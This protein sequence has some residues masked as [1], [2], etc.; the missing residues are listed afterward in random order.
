MTPRTVLIVDDAE[1]CR[2]TLEMAL[3]SL[4]GVDVVCVRSAEEALRLMH[5]RSV[6]ALIS[7]VQLEGMSGLELLAQIPGIPTIIVSAA[8]SRAVSEDALRA[9]AAAFFAKP[10]S[11]AAV[12]R[13]VEQ[14]LKESADV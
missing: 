7:D 13:K 1:D 3:Q 8:A 11:P 2:V 9:G 4:D 5:S 14:L 10:F 6:A 12:R